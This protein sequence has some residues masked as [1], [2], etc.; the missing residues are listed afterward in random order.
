MTPPCEGCPIE[1]AC[2]AFSGTC[3]VIARDAAARER[4]ILAHSR[5]SLDAS[6]AEV[7][8]GPLPEVKPHRP[9]GSCP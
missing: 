6:R 3:D 7:M 9:C 4:F 2:M 1:G 5:A 8:A